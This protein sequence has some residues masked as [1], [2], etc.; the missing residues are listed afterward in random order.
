MNE[1]WEK[2]KM[3]MNALSLFVF[4]DYNAKRNRENIHICTSTHKTTHLAM[5]FQHE[6]RLNLFL[7]LQKD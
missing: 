2:R 7:L 1:F 5:K 6:I 3:C 4:G